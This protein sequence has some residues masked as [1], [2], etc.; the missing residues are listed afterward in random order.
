MITLHRMEWSNWFSYEDN[1]SIDFDKSPVTQI[2]GSNGS[3]KSS[4]ILILQEMLYGKN[5]AGI[6]KTALRNRYTDGKLSGTLS[7]SKNGASYTISIRRTSSLTISLE[8]DGEDLSSHTSAGTYKTIEGIVGIDFKTFEQIVYQSSVSSLQF[9]TAT[10]TNRKA[11]LIGLLNLTE[12][13]ELHEKFKKI[14]KEVDASVTG[15]VATI[16]I[17]KKWLSSYEEKDPVEIV[18]VPEVDSSI[19]DEITELTAKKYNIDKENKLI[20]N[21]QSKID[22]LA[23]LKNQVPD[24]ELGNEPEDKVVEKQELKVAMA[25]KMIYIKELEGIEK[26]SDKCPTCYQ[27]ISQNLKNSMCA[28]RREKVK[29]LELR[30]AELEKEINSASLLKTEWKNH[31]DLLEKYATAESSIDLTLPNS[32][33]TEGSLLVQ[34]KE[35]QSK[36]HSQETLKTEAIKHNS[37]AEVVNEQIEKDRIKQEKL[38]KDLENA[39]IEVNKLTKLRAVLDILKNAFSTRGLVTYKIEYMIK[40]I[41]NLIN[42]YLGELSDGRFQLFFKLNGD[43]LN[44]DI[45]DNGT[46]IDISALSMGEKNRVNSATLLAIRAIMSSLSE[47]R[48]NLLFLDEI[49]GTLDTYGKEKLIELLL[50]EKDLNTFLVSHEYTHPLLDK[51]TVIKTENVSRIE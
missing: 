10:D 47:N 5:S 32:P 31:K 21:N 23:L 39:E 15:I 4:I 19:K 29:D 33:L 40:D 43:K 3:G 50:E 7:F 14:H 24:K 11:F 20:S 9:L 37:G 17:T 45:D 12:Y 6:K 46:T 38:S 30:V 16:N 49:L 1:N 2:I 36:L 8:C 26:L 13:L 22:A 48:I 35:L 28:D 34:I 41:E 18:D 51:L 27:E 42:N 25:Q 44:V